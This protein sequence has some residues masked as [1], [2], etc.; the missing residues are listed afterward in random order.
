MAYGGSWQKV[1]PAEHKI[2][3]TL[4]EEYA[5]DPL[6]LAKW[7]GISVTTV[8]KWLQKGATWR[9]KARDRTLLIFKECKTKGMPEDTSYTQPGATLSNNKN[10]ARSAKKKKQT[11]EERKAQQRKYWKDRKVAQRGTNGSTDPLRAEKATK[12]RE[13]YA[14]K[15]EAK[16]GAA[17]AKVDQQQIFRL[18]AYLRGLGHGT[19]V[20]GAVAL[21][22]LEDGGALDGG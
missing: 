11:A 1:T 15:K 5:K 17:Q 4:C 2:I 18:L 19:D 8:E 10:G 16:S 9:S 6:I 22:A 14:R 20:L 13:A 21:F 12:Q 3:K 7:L